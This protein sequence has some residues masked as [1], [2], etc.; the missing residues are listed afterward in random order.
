L[1]K[2]KLNILHCLTLLNHSEFVK[3]LV[4]QCPVL[5]NEYDDIGI[6]S[7]YIAKELKFLDISKLFGNFSSKEKMT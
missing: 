1:N 4:D 7:L 5:I 2:K 3:I 6:S